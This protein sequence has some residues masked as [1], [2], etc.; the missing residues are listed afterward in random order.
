MVCA[1]RTQ[2][3]TESGTA[4]AFRLLNAAPSSKTASAPDLFTSLENA[5]LDY[6]NESIIPDLVPEGRRENSPR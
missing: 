4:A 1:R 6:E 2:G 5:F 3:S